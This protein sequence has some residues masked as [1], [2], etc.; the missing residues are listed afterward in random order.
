MVFIIITLDSCFYSYVN[1]IRF[2]L[3]LIWKNT[4]KE[5]VTNMWLL[6]MH[7]INITVKVLSELLS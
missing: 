2:L 4:L 7:G 6:C 1:S 3:K 5:Q